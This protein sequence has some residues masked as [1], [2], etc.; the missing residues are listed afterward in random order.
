MNEKK[1][2]KHIS[3]DERKVIEKM[4]S[5]NKSIVE[6]AKVLNRNKTTIYREVKR[7]EPPYKADT[8]QLSL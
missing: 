6:I 4:L 7:V 5:E 3:Y 8:V 1:T 2:F